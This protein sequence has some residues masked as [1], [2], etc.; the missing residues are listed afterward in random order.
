VA[1]RG[2]SV[3]PGWKAWVWALAAAV[4]LGASLGLAARANADGVLDTAE[5]RYIEA[6]GASAICPVLDE[7][8]SKAGVFGVAEGIVDDGFSPDNAVDIINT[9]V[10]EYCPRHWSLLE[11]IG[12]EARGETRISGGVGGRLS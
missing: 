8:P 12:A 3:M 1:D 9:A 10:W 7:F 2:D 5:I 4:I 6:Y 11:G